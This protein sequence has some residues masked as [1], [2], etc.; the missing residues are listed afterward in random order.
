M[1]WSLGLACTAALAA[2]PWVLGCSDDTAAA[3]GGLPLCDT[4]GSAAT[5]AAPAAPACESNPADYAYP[6]WDPCQPLEAR[7]ANLLATLTIDEKLTLLNGSHP[8]VP[9][10]GLPGASLG[11]RRCT[12]SASP[13]TQ[14]RRRERSCRCR[15]SFPRCSASARAGTRR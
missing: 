10:I 6:F 14:M 13:R 5:A 11:T 7:L 12:A 1:K 3:P 15:R 2:A 4:G 9:R 8:A